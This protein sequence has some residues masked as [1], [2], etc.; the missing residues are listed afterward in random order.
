MNIGTIIHVN[1]PEDLARETAKTIAEAGQKCISE[2]GCFR[3][4]LSGGKTPRHVFRELIKDECKKVID[5]GK[6]EFFWTDERR[7]PVSHPDSNYGNA[8]Q[9]LLDHLGNVKAYPM[10]NGYESIKLA[11]G[12]FEVTLRD[13]FNL[14]KGEPPSFDVML[15]GI[16]TDGHVASLFPNRLEL[17]V[18]DKL[19]VPV[20]RRGT[21]YDRV[22]L[23]LPVIN[24]SSKNIFI[25]VGNEKKQVID[26]IQTKDHCLP[27]SMIEFENTKTQWIISN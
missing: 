26:S 6:V 3:L 5:W 2:K 25:A 9:L 22:T 18:K 10:I 8:H 14:E 20:K 7:V 21:D 19:C 16:G 11:S 24:A 13:R 17:K 4:A 12:R 1:S 27:A 23:T 15:L